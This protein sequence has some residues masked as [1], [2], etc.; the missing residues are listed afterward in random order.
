M[1]N[2]IVILLTS[3]LLFLSANTM[4]AGDAAAGKVKSASCMA[5]HGADGTSA[6]DMWPNLKGQKNG[7]L[8]KQIK[9]FRDGVRKDP[10]MS[11]MAAALTDEDI[12]NLAAYYSGL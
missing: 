4:A 6:T 9:A 5:C 10:M 7:Y 8:V 11:P 12:D 1:N 2:K 3:S